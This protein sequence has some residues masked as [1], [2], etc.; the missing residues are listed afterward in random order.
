MWYSK[1]NFG[2]QDYFVLLPAEFYEADILVDK[3][4]YPCVSGNE[5]ICR[6]FRYLDDN[7]FD[8]VKTDNGF[9]S[10]DGQSREPIR[11]FFTETEVRF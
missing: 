2:F 6:H 7:T 8:V 3:V 5:T 9:T 10:P 11:F 1:S 4:V